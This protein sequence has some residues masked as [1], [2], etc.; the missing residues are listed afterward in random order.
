MNIG[1]LTKVDPRTLWAKEDYDFTPWLAKEENISL[2]SDTIGLDLEVVGEEKGVGPFRADILCKSTVDDTFVLIENQLGRTDH[3]HL[4]QLMTYAAG[5]DAVNIVWI[6]RQFTEEH[7]AALDWLNRHTDEHLRFFGIELE[8]FRIGA[9]DPAPLFQLVSKPND[10]TKAVQKS[11][12]E[13][14]FTE[15]QEFYISYWSG[16]KEFFDERGT[17]LRNQKPRAQHWTNFA[18]GKSHFKL[19]AVASYRDNFL[20]VEFL[21]EGPDATERFFKLKEMFEEDSKVKVHPD[22]Q[23]DEVENRQMSY[24]YVKRTADISQTDKWPEQFE[25]FLENLERMDAFFRPKIKTI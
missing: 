11:R 15:V 14:E 16:M 25:W 10:W 6:A 4:G 8:V 5:L 3:S 7:R 19:A 24:A 21:L 12:R 13:S 17:K 1:R 23:W 22:I 9:S 20:R 2:L 18:L